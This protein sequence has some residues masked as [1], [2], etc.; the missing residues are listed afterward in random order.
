MKNGKYSL[1][2]QYPV[3][4]KLFRSFILFSILTFYSYLSPCQITTISGIVNSY[5]KVTDV[6]PAKACVKVTDAAGLNYNDKVMLVQ[7]KGASINTNSNSSSFGDTIS[8]NHAGNYEIATVCHVKDDSV[9]LVFMLLN[10]Y[11]VAG[12]VQLV[13]IPQYYS[14]DITDTLKPAPWNNTTGTG[15]V[16]AVSVEEDLLLNAPIYAD[17][18]G[19]QG[20]TYRLS[21]DNC[22]NASPANAYAYNAD[23]NDPTTQNG[24]FKGEGIADVA[25]TESGGRGAPANGG[26]GG[27]NHNNGGGGG[28]NLS[29]GGI[30]GG[31]SS[32]T[33]CLTPLQGIGGKAL[34]SYGG[35]KIFLG[36]GGGAGHVN[37][38]I[39][40]AYGGGNG[41]GIIFIQAKNLVGNNRKISANGQLG[42]HSSGDGA[43]GGGGGG[44][45][46]IGATNYVGNVTIEANGGQG[47][48]EDNGNI[49]GRCYGSGGGGS[50]GAVCFTGVVPPVTVSANGGNA[51]PETRRTASCN[52]AI[53]SLAGSAGQ[54]ISNYT[55]LRSFVLANSYCALLLPV[56]LA[57][58]KAVY[59]NGHVELN[60]KIDQPE[61]ADQF[62]IERSGDGGNWTNINRY[63]A[64]DGV[65]VYQFIDLFPQPKTN[66]YR[67]K[68]IDK[69]NIVNYSAVHKIFIPLK[70][71]LIKIYPNPASKK[72]FIT[73]TLP[74]LTEISLF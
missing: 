28:A 18:S 14:A 57:W 68:M 42:G 37:N 7:I 5:Y 41:G 56:E 21:G 12:K 64:I 46:I 61:I 32:S 70:N 51:G 74:A 25:N 69:S 52:P 49:A 73:G 2:P 19:F 53:P 45:I 47:G 36:G 17:A 35:T 13:K 34:S 58:F 6:I 39:L 31:N 30:G 72:V 24:A 48:T 27:N 50:G 29:A 3:K 71:N 8:L 16:L 43:S 9:F 60:W 66:F 26:G 65:S 20:G 40:N 10:Q 67:L 54:L 44:T 59:K 62:I 15:G 11:T 38:G 1:I 23:V 22:S 55:Y 33:G 63:T 4:L